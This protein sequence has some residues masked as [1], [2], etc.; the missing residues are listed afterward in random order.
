MVTSRCKREEFS[1]SRSF[2]ASTTAAFA[3]SASGIT[4]AGVLS[5]SAPTAI[6]AASSDEPTRSSLPSATATTDSSCGDTTGSTDSEA[7]ATAAASLFA[8]LVES[9]FDAEDVD[10]RPLAGRFFSTSILPKT[11]GPLGA[12]GFSTSSTTSD[13]TSDA[14]TSGFTASGC[15]PKASPTVWS[16]VCFF[17]FLSAFSMLTGLTPYSFKRS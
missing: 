15:S 3:G 8:L 5:C 4:S 9:A 2:T 11:F 1:S 14:A 13:F 6:A 10:A 17:A 16:T 12:F 7:V